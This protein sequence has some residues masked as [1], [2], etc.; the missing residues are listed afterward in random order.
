MTRLYT[1][2][3]TRQTVPVSAFPQLLQVEQFEHLG[4]AVLLLQWCVPTLVAPYFLKTEGEDSWVT[5]QMGH[6]LESGLAD[7]MV[8]ETYCFHLP[9][10]GVVES[11][12]LEL[13][14]L[15][16]YPASRPEV[17]KTHP[18]WARILVVYPALDLQD[19]VSWGLVKM[20]HGLLLLAEHEG[21]VLVVESL[22]GDE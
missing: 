22:Q 16:M 14:D 20:D 3:C 10:Q 11:E 12:I 2:C 9:D 7:L 8:T 19:E 17:E 1:I 5:V 6:E 4:L 13:L 18:E 15:Q 21:Q